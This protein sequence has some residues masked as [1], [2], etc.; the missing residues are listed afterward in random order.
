[1]QTFN[2]ATIPGDGIGP[3]VMQSAKAVLT[4]LAQVHG[5]ISFDFIEQS[6]GCQYFLEH[7]CMMPENALDILGDSDTILL[8]A[9]GFPTVP[10][11][12]SLWGLLIPIRRRFDQYVCLRPV[13]LL[14][15]VKSPLS[16]QDNTSIDYVVVREN[17]EGEYSQVGGRIHMNTPYESVTQVTIFTRHGTERIIR[18]A[19]E[20][21]HQQQRSLVTSATKSNGI[22]HTMPYWDEIFELIASEYP[23]IKSEKM[24]VDALAAKL[25][26]AP[27]RFEVIVGSNLFGDILTDLGAAT[28][29]SIGIAASANI[30]P[31]RDYPSMFEPVHGSAPDI[32]GQGIANPLGQV[33]SSAMMLDHL[34]ETETARLLENAMAEVLQTGIRTPDLGGSATTEEVTQAL[35]DAV[36]RMSR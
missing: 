27:E 13:K 31:E 18:Y 3:E 22:I 10:D 7:G 1:M 12:V 6:W 35:R 15:G 2:I 16:L 8:G 26:L 4:T 19:F 23:D 17:T 36:Q 28:V 24:H 9:V 14:P 29:G 20:L 21:A 34:G 11:H 5:G 33:W 30:N 32:V 25:V